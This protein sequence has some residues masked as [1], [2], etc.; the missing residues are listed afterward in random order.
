MFDAD[1]LV[2]CPGCVLPGRPG[3]ALDVPVP[4]GLP[5][6]PV[7]VPEVGDADGLPN[8]PVTSTWWPTWSASCTLDDPATNC[9]SCP[10]ADAL[11]E[12]VLLEEVLLDA[13]LLDDDDPRPLE[14][15]S[16]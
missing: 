3:D 2:D 8:V 14:L 10:A 15:R 4:D 16:T 9:T 7:V 5:V 13:V 1:G 11:G 6:V 12:A